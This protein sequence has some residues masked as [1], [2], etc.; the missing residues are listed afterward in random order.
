MLSRSKKIYCKPYLTNAIHVPMQTQYDSQ[1]HPYWD[2]HWD[3]KWAFWCQKQ[4]SIDGAGDVMDS[5]P[6][7]TWYYEVN[8]VK[9]DFDF[10]CQLNYLITGGMSW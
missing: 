1:A 8:Q 2:R 9:E 5:E 4:A 10:T 6:N 7:H 3:R